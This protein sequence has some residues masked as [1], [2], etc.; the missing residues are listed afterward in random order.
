MILDTLIQTSFKN[1]TNISRTLNNS[2]KPVTQRMRPSERQ[3]RRLV[4]GPA[5]GLIFVGI[6]F[7]YM[8]FHC[9]FLFVCVFILFYFSFIENFLPTQVR[10]RVPLAPKRKPPHPLKHRPIRIRGL[11][12]PPVNITPSGW[13]SVDEETF[14]T[15]LGKADDRTKSPAYQELVKRLPADEVSSMKILGW[16][17]ALRTAHVFYSSL[18]RMHDGKKIGQ[19]SKKTKKK[20]W[21]T[22][23]IS[24]NCVF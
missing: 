19:K 8:Q 15:L 5:K 13:P 10:A 2:K 21:R 14:K 9:F 12:L 7:F 23:L 22:D 3:E 17:F 16:I 4:A 11:S 18:E 20:T 1:G 24:R 6:F